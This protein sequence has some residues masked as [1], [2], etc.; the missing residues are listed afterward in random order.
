MLGEV[1]AQGGE[2]VDPPYPEGDL[3][4]ST[5]RDPSGNVFGVWQRGPRG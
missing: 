5:F 4:V 3:W 2:I 1:V